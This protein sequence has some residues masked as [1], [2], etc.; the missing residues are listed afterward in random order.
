MMACLPGELS[1]VSTM[2]ARSR[3]ETFAE[4]ASLATQRRLKASAERRVSLTDAD[5]TRL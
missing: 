1:A 4:F 3:A 2:G 5:G